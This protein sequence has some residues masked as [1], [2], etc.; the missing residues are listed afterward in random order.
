MQKKMQLL[1]ILTLIMT[2]VILTGCS[3]TEKKAENPQPTANAQPVVATPAPV[4]E[5]KAQA[6]LKAI[7][8]HGKWHGEGNGITFDLY[9]HWD[10]GYF[11]GNHQIS[12]KFGSSV[13]F[14]STI[15]P[16]DITITGKFTNKLPQTIAWKS[17]RNGNGTAEVTLLDQN[18]LQWRTLTKNG[19]HYFPDE[20]ILKRQ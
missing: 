11:R 13:R 2:C 7:D 14:D 18:V 19:E 1:L 4:E 8:L 3:R 6:N 16:K 9:L 17:M 15:S 12:R 10:E 20:M 5:Q